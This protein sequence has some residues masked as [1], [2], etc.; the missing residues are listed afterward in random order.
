VPPGSSVRSLQR[1]RPGT[2][3]RT[4]AAP[5]AGWVLGA[6]A[7]GVQGGAAQKRASSHAGCR[8]VGYGGGG[9]R[10][11]VCK[12]G[13]QQR[14][15][16]RWRRAVS[17][18]PTSR[19]AGRGSISLAA[20]RALLLLWRD[21]A[22][23]GRARRGAARASSPAA[24]QS[25]GAGGGAAHRRGDSVAGGCRVGAKEAMRGARGQGDKGQSG[26]GAGGKG[27]RGQRAQ[28]PRGQGG[29]GARGLAPSR[30][31]MLDRGGEA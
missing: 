13:A 10:A 22:E 1:G 21:R 29:K 11:L 27:Q 23:G 8:W 9:K 5:P 12:R 16:R 6:P 24:R 4:P 20:V 31:G 7:G 14:I 25:G 3:N 15:R 17:N 26:K 19:K 18:G 2:A 30:E 28:A